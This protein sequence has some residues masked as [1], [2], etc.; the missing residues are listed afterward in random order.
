MNKSLL[1]IVV[2]VILALTGCVTTTSNHQVS[3]A[4]G[5]EPF[6]IIRSEQLAPIPEGATIGIL[7]SGS[8]LGLFT[9]AA[10]DTKGL[11][12]RELD[13]YTLLPGVKI[14]T[15]NP[16]EQYTFLNTLV[17]E[18]FKIAKAA[19]ENEPAEDGGDGAL[20]D[21]LDLDVIVDRLFATDDIVAEEQRANHYLS[22]VQSLRRM[23]ADLNVD[24]ILVSGAPYTGLCYSTRIYD[25]QTL[26]VVF[27]DFIVANEEEWRKVVPAP[28]MEN[29]ISFDFANEKEPVPYW[30]F[31]YAEFMVSKLE[32]E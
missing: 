11:V 12:V 29:G 18:T 31:S 30:D 3:A 10:L 16:Q 5:T 17:E 4:N 23:V 1:L 2:P 9:G 28:K 13:L 19:A 6:H 14:E 22:L 24:Y 8:P 25:T 20:A 26:D 21:N 15:I 27:R 7:G 32:L